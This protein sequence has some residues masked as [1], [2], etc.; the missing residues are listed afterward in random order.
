VIHPNQQLIVFKPEGAPELEKG[1]K[2]LYY[3]V[4][5]GDTL[6]DIAKMYDGVTVDQIKRL[7]NISNTKRLKPGQKIKIAVNS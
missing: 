1:Q 3:T 7:N 5:R 4:R 2:Y 6:W